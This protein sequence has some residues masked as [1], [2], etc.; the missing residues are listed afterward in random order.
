VGW[1]FRSVWQTVHEFI[2]DDCMSIGA[3]I[4]YYAMFS[5]PPL[6]VL[7][8]MIAGYFGVRPE[9][10]RKSVQDQWGVAATEK[11]GEQS[12]DSGAGEK[13][14]ANEKPKPGQFSWLSRIVGGAILLFSATGLFAQLQYALNRAWGLKADPEKGGIVTYVV[15][16]VLSFGMI[17]VVF[18]LLLVSMVLTT[19]VDEIVVYVRG[20]VAEGAG[21]I[22]GMVLNNVASF[23]VAAVLFAAMFK[24]L[25]DA[26]TA[27]RDVWVG[28]CITA[29]LF[30]VGKALIGWYLQHTDLSSSW[31]SAAASML[32]VLTWIYYSSLILLFGAEFT[33]VWASEFG[34]G[35][36][37][38]AP[39]AAKTKG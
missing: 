25:P 27:W 3:A 9:Q 5:L 15:K 22:V 12:A 37:P 2:N 38:V 11:A 39:A 32:G 23:A 18:F 1:F 21:L 26:K 31:G 29:L 36:K 30:I 6:L 28:A 17:I 14:A 24:I 35:I 4:A 13:S 34:R 8:L 7:V 20:D 33:Q 16:R 19:L 10:I